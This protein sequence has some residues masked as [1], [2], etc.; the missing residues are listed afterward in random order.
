MSQ[1][2]P[3]SQPKLTPTR[4]RWSGLAAREA[5]LAAWMLAPAFIIVFTIV[6]FPVV[7][8]FWISFKE[9]QLSDLR[10]PQALARARVMNFPESAGEALSLRYQLRNSSRDVQ[11]NDVVLTASLPAGLT[12]DALAEGCTFTADTL[13]CTLGSWDGGY[14]ENLELS[15]L[16]SQTFIDDAS[17]D[18]L[19]DPFVTANAPNVLTSWEFTLANFR[20]VVSAREF[21]TTLRTTLAYTL[22]GACGSI[23][24]G[25]CAAQLL[26]AEFPLRGL[27]RG[28][29]L[30]P[31]V[32]PVIAVAFT[33]TFLLDPFSGSLNA[34]GLELGVLGEPISFLSQRSLSVS[35][36][37]LE[38]TLPLALTSVILFDAWRYFPFAFLFIL[39][40]FQAIPAALYE[41]AKVDGAGPFAQFWFITLPQLSL[42]ISTLFLLR[43]IW[44]FNKFDDIFLLTGGTAG[45]RT[46]P[47]LVYDNAFGREDIGMGAAT[48]VILFVMLA[49][50][51]VVYFR[52]T[53]EGE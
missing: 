16:A 18:A 49:A 4:K 45:T 50:F 51:L 40:R 15:W 8:N 28:L 46:L 13:T 41:S 14:R 47:V 30:F 31:Y 9:V 39:A 27:L 36:L 35:L 5:R 7:A 21:W 2:I 38:L 23:L 43:F 25:L 26:N 11:L 19:S 22:F 34:L 1:A 12:A 20:A 10:P 33:W 24:L 37:G 53:P 32:A 44:T 17:E 42:V 52:Y 3:T 29:L 6:I 48:A